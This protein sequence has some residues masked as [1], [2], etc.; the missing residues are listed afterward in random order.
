MEIPAIFYL[1]VI[2]ATLFWGIVCLYFTVKRKGEDFFGCEKIILFAL[3]LS[4]VI[5]RVCYV[6]LNFEEFRANLSDI[7][8]F[9]QGGASLAAAVFA[10]FALAFC[11][12]EVHALKAMLWFD[13]F[14]IPMIFAAGAHEVALN[15]F[16]ES[17][18]D[19]FSDVA[20]SV[21]TTPIGFTDAEFLQS[22]ALIEGVLTLILAAYLSRL[23]KYDN[24]AVFF[25]GL[26]TF[27]L[28]RFC[29][30][31]FFVVSTPVAFSSHI[32]SATA[33]LLFLG[34]FLFTVKTQPAR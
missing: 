1:C 15:L 30:A 2:T 34:L 32:A 9:W 11:Y 28:I 12:C 13:I 26:G 20:P 8:L 31:F 19:F 17:A 16:F 24:G 7:F 6:M 29:S 18:N 3:P 23:D 10:F 5:G 22:P 4:V 27:S 33:A 25:L 14:I 21:T